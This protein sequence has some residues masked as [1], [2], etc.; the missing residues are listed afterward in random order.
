MWCFNFICYYRKAEPESEEENDH[1]EEFYFT[2]IDVPIEGRPLP[3]F[4]PTTT[5]IPP[6]P[7]SPPS[8][9]FPSSSS[10]LSLYSSPSVIRS[11]V[12]LNP[13]TSHLFLSVVDRKSPQ[14]DA[15]TPS[16][17]FT[18]IAAAAADDINQQLLPSAANAHTSSPRTGIQILA[19]GPPTRPQLLADHMDMARPP[20]ENPEY[21]HSVLITTTSSAP[22]AAV[23]I[24]IPVAA[25]SFSFGPS[26][27]HSQQTPR[28]QPP[29][30][31]TTSGS[32]PH[33]SKYI[34]LSP[35]PLTSSTPR[36]PK[37]RKVYGMEKKEQWCTQCKWKK[38][39]TRF[40]ENN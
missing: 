25:A 29:T 8:S 15:S 18:Q 33:Q 28:F 39:C 40:G 22:V 19:S 36:S 20:H 9:S 6:S 34:R 3:A 11:I 2:E 7:S 35:K 10:S 17:N 23:P 1:E 27:A 26:N 4:S 31:T 14:Y 30:F 12:L 32:S 5:K 16:R 13:T 21:R 38:A 37:C 24:T